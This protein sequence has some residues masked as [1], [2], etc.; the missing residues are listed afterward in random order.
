[1]AATDSFYRNVK[2]LHIVF[3]VSSVLTL[4]VTIGMF[5]EDYFREWKI[6]QRVFRTVEEEMAIRSLLSKTPSNEKQNEII[7]LEEEM[8]ALN[9]VKVQAK[10]RIESAMGDLLSNKLK[11]ENEKADVKAKF[12]SVMSFYNQA[13]DQFGPQ[14]S[15]A[16]KY[17]TDLEQIRQNLTK[18]S[19]EVDANQQ[20]YDSDF[21]TPL[22][23]NEMAALPANVQT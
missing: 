6:E 17:K 4:L 22:T 10:A 16:I 3:A 7:Q 19:D 18:V 21:A 8:K 13:V 15:Q 9:S 23:D 5:S 2:T 12:D 1:M 20:Q 14:S 11:K